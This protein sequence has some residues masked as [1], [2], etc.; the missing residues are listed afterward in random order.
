MRVL[1]AGAGGFI[2]KHLV[3]A[4]LQNDCD[5][6][7]VS[8]DPATAGRILPARVS[9]LG[10][11]T[12]ALKD[13]IASSQVVVNLAG[14]PIGSAPWTDRKKAAIVNSRLNTSR[15]LAGLVKS[16]VNK[17]VIFV[18]ASAIGYYGNQ[19][20]RI[21]MEEA[22]PGNG[23]LADTCLKWESHIPELTAH[24]KKCLVVRIGL[25]LGK[26]GGLLPEL[27]KQCNRRT[28]GRLG[29]GSQWMSWIHIYDLVHAVA[30][31]ITHDNCRGTYNMVAPEP[32]MQK[33]F[34][35][36]LAAK[37]NKKLQLSA[38]AFAVKLMLGERGRELLL[39]GQKAS[40]HK[41]LQHGFVFKYD[42]LPNALDDLLLNRE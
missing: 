14:D 20:D 33:D 6:I 11:D 31:L 4:F 10:Y 25:V 39:S 32:A 40:A 36:L 29:G 12:P 8:R 28:G 24:V 34:A 7:A 41:L 18:Q 3:Q 38:P 19:G 13:A 27:I 1:I 2:G 30:Y 23:F 17:D 21:C 16:S 9:A 22:L 37:C 26:D 15:K 42:K 5:I 35:G